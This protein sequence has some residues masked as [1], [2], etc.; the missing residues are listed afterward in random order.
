MQDESA[1]RCRIYTLLSEQFLLLLPPRR[2]RK[3]G[4]SLCSMRNTDTW[5][6]G[7]ED[8]PALVHVVEDRC[9][10]GEELRLEGDEHNVFRVQVLL[11]WR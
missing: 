8:D 11:S 7:M 3:I 2:K 1:R 5:P 9:Q 6:V 4:P 10:H